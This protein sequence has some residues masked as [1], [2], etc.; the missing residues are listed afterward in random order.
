MSD[1]PGYIDDL[2][3]DEQVTMEERIAARIFDDPAVTMREEDAAQL[4]RDILYMVLR[5][6][7]PDLFDDYQSDKETT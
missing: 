3:L 2:D 5:E 1:N 7:R 6:F 4:G